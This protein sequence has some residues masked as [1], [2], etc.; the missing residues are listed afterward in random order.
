M[1]LELLDI[2]KVLGEKHPYVVNALNSER[3]KYNRS[4]C[5]NDLGV[6]I[7]L[8]ISSRYDGEIKYKHSGGIADFINFAMKNGNERF[9]Y[10]KMNEFIQEAREGSISLYP[11][12][13]EQYGKYWDTIESVI[14]KCK[15]IIDEGIINTIDIK[16]NVADG[17]GIILSRETPKPY[18]P[19]VYDFGPSNKVVAD[20]R[21]FNKE[22]VTTV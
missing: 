4:S 19:G 10:Q 12:K 5:G 8:T 14:K 18:V 7:S 2:I 21:L 20:Y 3:I 22:T 6:R 17:V 13:E 15:S 11:G 9:V 1:T 16:I